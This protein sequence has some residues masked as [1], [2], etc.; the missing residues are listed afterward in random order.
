MPRYL[1]GRVSRFPSAIDGRPSKFRKSAGIGS[2]KTARTPI[3]A[4]VPDDSAISTSSTP[5]IQFR[6]TPSVMIATA[7]MA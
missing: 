7:T 1:P 5:T 6:P 2:I 4:D 3:F